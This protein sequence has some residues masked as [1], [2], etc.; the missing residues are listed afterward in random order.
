MSKVEVL[1]WF[2]A[3]ISGSEWTWK[4]FVE[5]TD[6]GRYSVTAKQVVEEGPAQRVR[7]YRGLQ[8]PSE[9]ANAI[10]LIVDKTGG[11]VEEY[12]ANKIAESVAELS[13]PFA[14]ELHEALLEE[15][16]FDEAESQALASEYEA[17]QAAAS[18]PGTIGA[19]VAAATWLEE[20][21]NGA[22]GM[23]RIFHKHLRR[24][25]AHWYASKYLQEHGSLPTGTHR[26]VATYGGSGQAGV[27]IP[28]FGSFS[29]VVTLDTEITY[30]ELPGIDGENPSDG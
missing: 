18:A 16:G 30:P 11:T 20:R 10:V 6:E 27:D 17:A 23:V 3:N 1:S 8:S 29:R 25:A 7:G 15:L 28:M 21:W 14:M 12:Q 13:E 5:L 19:H 22:G 24:N 2:D 9:V 26:V 4:I